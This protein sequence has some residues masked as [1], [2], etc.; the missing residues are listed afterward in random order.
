MEKQYK[1]LHLLTG[2]WFSRNTYIDDSDNLLNNLQ[3]NH[4]LI[5]LLPIFTNEPCILPRIELE[6]A[7]RNS[8]KAGMIF[9]WDEGS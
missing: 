4:R 1:L 5:L 7:I 3:D 9:I 2:K 8:I 6:E